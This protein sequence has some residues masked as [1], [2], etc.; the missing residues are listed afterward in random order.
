[1]RH[2][3][4]RSRPTEVI[5]AAVAKLVKLSPERQLIRRTADYLAGGSNMTCLVE[6][7]GLEPATPW[8]RSLRRQ[9]PR[10]SDSALTRKVR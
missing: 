10:A 1:V 6:L 5:G 4:R 8:V 2:P 3:L 9:V 7:A